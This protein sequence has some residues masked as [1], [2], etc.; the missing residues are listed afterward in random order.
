MITASGLV[1]APAENVYGFLSQLHNHRLISGDRLHLVSLAADREGAQIVIRGPLGI[2]RT[3]ET[4]ITQRKPARG[5]GGTATVGSRTAAHV[6]WTII[7]AGAGSHIALTA[8]ILR[9]GVLDRLLLALG[10]DRWLARGFDRAIQRLAAVLYE[11]VTP[12]H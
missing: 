4:T 9:T 7:P 12:G 5:V 8:T 1:D 2:R 10:G 11:P 6:H 3:A